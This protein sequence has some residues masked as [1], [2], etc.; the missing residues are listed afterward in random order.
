MKEEESKEKN[1]GIL[2]A[3]VIVFG[4]V[5][6]LWVGAYIY[7]SSDKNG[8]E[9]L[10]SLYSAFAFAAIV[11]TI[12]LQREEIKLIQLEL[13]RQGEYNQEQIRANGARHK[14]EQRVVRPIIRLGISGSSQNELN[15]H[16]KNITE[17]RAS[18]IRVKFYFKNETNEFQDKFFQVVQPNSEVVFKLSIENILNNPMDVVIVYQ[19][20]KGELLEIRYSAVNG[21]LEL[22]N[23]LP[24]PVL[25]FSETEIGN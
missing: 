12:W 3:S 2:T 6:V 1:I 9:Y 19:S 24:I 4:L 11:V 5:V 14:M 10:N 17:N 21:Q 22:K 20:P 16:V 15:F 23:P 8:G 7:F 18:S 13:R 25:D